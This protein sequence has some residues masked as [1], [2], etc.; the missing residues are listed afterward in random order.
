MSVELVVQE[1]CN[2]ITF[3]ARDLAIQT[4]VVI[5]ASGAERTNPGGL[6]ILYG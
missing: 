6:D 3:H 1:P 4:G 2:A 5:D